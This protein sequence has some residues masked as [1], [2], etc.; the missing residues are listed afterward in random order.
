M[1]QDNHAV[2]IKTSL[3]VMV[4]LYK[5]RVWN[6]AKT[7]N[8]IA[9]AC[10]SK[11]TKVMVAAVKF[12]IGVD[13]GVEEESDSEFEEELPSLKQVR[14]A[15]KV[16]KT[17][18]KGNKKEERVKQALKKREKKKNKKP[19]FDFSAIHLIH[20]PQTLADK[21]YKKLQKM[22]ERFEV[23]LMLMNLI[24]RLIGI[25]ELYLPNFYPLIQRFLFVHQREVTKIMT[26][27]AQAAHP[28]VPPD[29]LEPVV[30]TLA[31][32]FVTE[33]YSGE[34]M[35]MGINAIR[36]LCARNAYCMSEDLLQDLAAYKTHKEKSVCMAARSLIALFRAKNPHLLEKKHRGA[37]T[38]LS[39]ESRARNFGE[40]DA[41]DF[42]P[43][44]EVLTLMEEEQANDEEWED[45]DS[46][47][48]DSDSD[49][50]SKT[51]KERTLSKKEAIRQVM[52]LTPEERVER[53][54]DV[55]TTR[56]LTDADFSRI[57]AV[58][59]AK[60]VERYSSGR[61]KRK[62][63]DDGDGEGQRGEIVALSRIEM[64]HKKRCHDKDERLR[65][66]LEGREGREKF[67]SRKGR[68]NPFASTTN[69]EKKKAKNFMMMKHKIRSNKKKL[70]F[71]ERQIKLR[72][73]LL[74]AKLS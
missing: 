6:D 11:I 33:R 27:A 1:L 26:Y 73:A 70:S 13:E 25:H 63:E 54:K 37:P 23:K 52:N 4:E 7:V 35:A 18:K 29:D 9:S 72:K 65:T 16:N 47:D 46:S 67:G 56:I 53:A 5:K 41:T 17:R 50:E 19:T 51:R 49:G 36:E 44:A 68:L 34:V 62:L 64:I 2:S 55:M 60:E 74:K 43:G 24:S 61:K 22:N 69:R 30:K 3:D 45:A 28:L 31:N 58:Q 66:V 21:L 40:H 38:E 12:F 15:A 71:R 48:S 57:E 32:N 14:M 8:I 10:F 59:A 39:K 20:D 42:I